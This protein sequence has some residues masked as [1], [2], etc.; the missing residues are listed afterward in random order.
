VRNKN[1]QAIW[2]SNLTSELGGIFFT[3]CISILIF[4]K[5]NS[6]TALGSVWLIYYIPSFFMQLFIGPYID[7]WSRKYTMVVCQIIRMFLALLLCTL[8]FTNTFSIILLYFIQICI[9]LIMPVFSPASQTILPTVVRQ[10][11]LQKANASLDSVRQLAAILGPILA[12]LLFDYINV[13][14]I[15][16]GIAF[17]FLLSV[18][19]LIS[20]EEPNVKRTVRQPWIKEFK[21]G[22]RQYIA[23]PLVVTLGIFFGFVQFGVGVTIVTTLPF[24]TSILEQPYVSYGI[25]KA[26]FPI[27]YIIGAMVTSKV[28]FKKSIFILFLSL[29]IGGL[30]YLSLAITPWFVLAIITECIAGIVIAIFNIFNITL[31]QKT[32]L[33]SAMGKVTS[34]RLLIMRTMLPL[35]ILI[36]TISTDW[37][38]I[39]QMY[40]GIGFII[41]I[42]AIIGYVYVQNHSKKIII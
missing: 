11:L 5:T 13:Q 35:G 30:T 39:R 29:F 41:C 28:P 20:I 23:N 40:F 22:F 31:I 36:A 15:L 8:I 34:I 25:F 7:R 16:L 6:V 21:D 38:T 2:L 24:I 9:G 26:G 33:E 32:T 18:I 14:W 12:G 1:Y 3:V 4:D 10:D 19:A 37:L 17:A 27:G 42:S